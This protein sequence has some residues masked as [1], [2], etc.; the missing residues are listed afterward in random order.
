MTQAMIRSQRSIIYLHI[1]KMLTSKANQLYT[2]DS[3]KHNL[4][5]FFLGSVRV[6]GT[7]KYHS[8][9]Q[10]GGFYC[11]I[12]DFSRSFTEKKCN[13]AEYVM[14]AFSNDLA[15]VIWFAGR[16]FQ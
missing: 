11:Q 1:P 10:F 2:D 15:G 14:R 9:V 6:T 16:Q 3:N 12:K 13:L 8:V 4:P 7:V 5:C